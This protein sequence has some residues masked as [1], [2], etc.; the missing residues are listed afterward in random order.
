MFG[1]YPLVIAQL[2]IL[3]FLLLRIYRPGVGG[4][5]HAYSFLRREM[6]QQKQFSVEDWITVSIVLTTVLLWISF[7]DS[8]GLGPVALIGVLLCVVSGVLNWDDISHDVNWGVPILYAS[9]ISMGLWMNST[10]A[11]DWVAGRLHFLL[12]FESG[13]G[14][15]LVIATLTLLSMLCG[16]FL[17]SGPA[18]ALMGPVFLRQAQLSGADP[19]VFG[20]ILV[21][22]ASYAH[23]TPVS[24]P[25]CMIIYGCGLVDKTDYRAVGLRLASISFLVIVA[26]AYFYWPFVTSYF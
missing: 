22:G 23:F 12:A 3:C 8:L 20:M 5:G 1:M 15:L 11:A 14:E 10:G 7:S 4:L 2:P 6:H 25:A 16:A 26:F 21:A 19:L 9:I 24:S 18:I 13:G 17:G